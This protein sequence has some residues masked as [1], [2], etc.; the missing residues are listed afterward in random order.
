MLD[1]ESDPTPATVEMRLDGVVYMLLNPV[2][3]EN[4]DGEEM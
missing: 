4:I 3:V 1:L 2:T